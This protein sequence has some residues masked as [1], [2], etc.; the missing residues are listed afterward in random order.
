MSEAGFTAVLELHGK[1]ATGIEVPPDV[2]EQLGAGRRP[3]VAVTIGTHTWTTALGTMGGRV[4]IPVN[5]ENRSAAG[6]VAGQTV[7][8]RLAVATQPEVEVPDDL[9]AALDAAGVRPAFDALARSHRKEHVRSVVE[10]KQA[11]T[12]ERRVAAVVTKLQG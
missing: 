12:R 6:L 11:A 7:E 2:V 5:A 9:A 3:T 4:L 8:V 1:T 10:A